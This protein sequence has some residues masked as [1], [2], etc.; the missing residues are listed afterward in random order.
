MF[1]I[2][3]RLPVGS[4]IPGLLALRIGVGGI[5]KGEHAFYL[6]K[7]NTNNIGK[8]FGCEGNN[9]EG[10]NSEGNNSEGNNS[11]GNN[12]EGNNRR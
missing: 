9:S 7:S 3:V 5:G 12:S 2:V 8:R 6:L 4:L 10:N 1:Q 11:E